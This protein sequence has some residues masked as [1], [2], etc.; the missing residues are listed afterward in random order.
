MLQKLFGVACVAIAIWFASQTMSL[1]RDGLIAEGTVVGE[2]HRAEIGS[3]GISLTHAPIVEF[4]PAGA[5]APVRFRSDVWFSWSA[6]AQ[7]D[8]VTVR[9]RAESPEQA[10]VDSVLGDLVLPAVLLL[11][12]LAGLFGR[13]S[14]ERS[15]TWFNKY[16]E[17]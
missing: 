17:D 13:L 1:R 4:V 9:Y 11:L 14:G 10:R 15:R 3:D 7:G 12:G 6:H 8:K 5:K 2:R 16:W